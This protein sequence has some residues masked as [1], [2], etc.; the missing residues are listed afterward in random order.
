VPHRLLALALCTVSLAGCVVPIAFNP[1]AGPLAAQRP[2]PGYVA[3]IRDVIFGSGPQGHLAVALEHG[4]IFR[5]TWGPAVPSGAGTST[6]AATRELDLTRDWDS[7]YGAG[8]FSAHVRG[9]PLH[10]RASLAGS[11]GST[12]VVEVYNEHNVCGETRGVARDSHGNLYRVTVYSD[13]GLF[14]VKALSNGPPA[15]QRPE[16]PGPRLVI[17]ASGGPPVLAIPVGGGLYQR[18]TGGPPQPGTPVD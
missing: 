2:P 13:C 11:A 14:L 10:A 1:V 15:A 8:Y 16:P 4:E 18:V 5:G 9:S 17:F 3:Q 12:A 6:S 7:V